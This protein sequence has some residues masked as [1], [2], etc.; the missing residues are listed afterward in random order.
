M[1]TFDEKSEK[2]VLFDDL[3]LTNLKIHNKITEDNTIEYFHPLLRRDALQTFENINSLT[4]KNLGEPLAVFPRKYVKTQLM[5]TA[6][7]KFKKFVFNSANQKLVDFPDEFQ[8]LAKDASR[9][10]T[11]TI[12]EQFLYARKPPHLK[13]SKNR[14]DVDNGPNEKVVT[15]IEKE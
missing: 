9:K 14:P 12:L 5:A 7:H 8:K 1:A 10:A 2:F 3:F 13:K 6:K 15:Y 11:H 4:R